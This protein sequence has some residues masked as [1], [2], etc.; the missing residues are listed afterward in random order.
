MAIQGSQLFPPELHARVVQRY[1]ADAATLTR[2][3]EAGGHRE[4]R[5]LLIARR[6]Q[7]LRNA[8]YHMRLALELQS[9]VPAAETS[10]TEF[11]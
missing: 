4:P 10:L 5:S 3:I 7:R 8:D 6:D 9:A 11:S 2:T 1:T